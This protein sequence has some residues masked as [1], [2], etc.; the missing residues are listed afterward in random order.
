MAQVLNHLSEEQVEA[1][2][3]NTMSR[4]E[5]VLA[6][7]HLISCRRC[8]ERTKRE[9]EFFSALF[10]IFA[11]SIQIEGSPRRRNLFISKRVQ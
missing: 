10:A 7:M 11:R 2:A 1:Y 4:E 8:R 3:Q 5:K 6:N 9:L